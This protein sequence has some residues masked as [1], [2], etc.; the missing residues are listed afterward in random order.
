MSVANSAFSLRKD[1]SRTTAP[2][3]TQPYRPDIDGLRAIAVLAVVGYHAFPN[4]ILGGFVGVDVFFVISGYLITRTLLASSRSGGIDLADFYRRRVRR[5]IPALL[6]VLSACASVGWYVML[7][8]EFKQLGRHLVGGSLFA[9]N[10]VLWQESG[11]FDRPAEAKPLLHLWSLGIE[12]QFYIVFPLVLWACLRWRLRQLRI[13]LAGALVSLAACI[14]LTSADR[15]SAF[16]SPLTRFWELLAGGVLASVVSNRAPDFW[17][18]AGSPVYRSSRQHLA[19]VLGAALIGGSMLTYGGAMNFPGFSAVVPVAGTVLIIA[20]GP[21]GLLNRAML[22]QRV[23]VSVGRISY[24]LYLWHWPLLKFLSIIKGVLINAQ[25]RIGIVC[26]SFVVAWLTYRFV[27]RPVRWRPRAVALLLLF[28][29]GIAVFGFGAAS[30][31]IAPRQHAQNLE[32]IVNAASDWQFP[33]PDFPPLFY[34]GNRFFHQRTGRNETTLFIGDSNVEQY[35]ARINS[36]LR[37]NYSQANSVVIAT[38]GGCL[39]IPGFLSD[40]F[41]CA[42]RLDAALRYAQRPEVDTVVIGGYWPS[43]PNGPYRATA[44]QAIAGMIAQLTPT[45]RVFLLLSIPGGPEFDPRNMFEGSRWTQLAPKPTPT[46]FPLSRFRAEHGELLNALSTIGKTHGATVIDPIPFLCD[47]VT[48]NVLD[49]EGSPLYMDEHHIRPS[50]ALRSATFIDQTLRPQP[51]QLQ[52][53][54]SRRS[55]NVSAVAEQRAADCSVSGM[56]QRVC[57]P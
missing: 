22:S 57:R 8:D 4:F 28:L 20:A 29:A 30:G 23:L 9:S 38:R 39:P 36:V 34:E 43:M 19:S 33:S 55:P 1:T 2:A 42:P 13:L 24:P 3:T 49:P 56:A 45:K 44:L 11:Y 10:A 31:F 14:A 17:R 21:G 26:L 48:C 18:A 25:W 46:L 51:G 50:Q 41:P 54:A 5:I 37:A 32:R 53:G 47:P 52:P 40:S 16:Y 27:E 12:E 6:V 7:S 15:V 35:A